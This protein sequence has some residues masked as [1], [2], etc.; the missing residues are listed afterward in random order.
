MRRELV[1]LPINL[2]RVEHPREG[3]EATDLEGLTASLNRVG[4][5]HPIVVQDPKSCKLIFGRR[6]LAAA[7][8]AGW[9]HVPCIIA[10]DLATAAKVLRAQLDENAERASLTPTERVRLAKQ[11]E[12]LERAEAEKRRQAGQRTLGEIPHRSK[13]RARDKVA[14][15]VGVDR[16]TLDKAEAIVDAAEADP[17][18]FGDIAE[19]MDSSGKV[20]PAYQELQRR[21]EPTGEA[22]PQQT[23]AVERLERGLAELREGL[24]LLRAASKRQPQ[25]PDH[26]RSRIRRAAAELGKLAGELPAKPAR[27]DGKS[28]FRPGHPAFEI[29]VALLDAIRSHSPSF[30]EPD[31]QQWA[32]DADRM[33]RLDHRSGPEVLALIKWCHRGEGSSFWAGNVL[34]VRKLRLQ[35]DQLSIKRRNGA[36][37]PTKLMRDPAEKYAGLED[38]DAIE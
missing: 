21:Q 29:A 9:T 38:E 35:F 7:T 5:L 34:S 28:S 4:M 22:L 1:E 32:A 16:R 8:K 13:G 31:L 19:K 30:K 11:L 17:A 15:A 23:E 26:L 20:S 25:L 24:R 27:S 3:I 6:R 10:P 37:R 14:K 36:S 18:A 33:I 2:I 12:P